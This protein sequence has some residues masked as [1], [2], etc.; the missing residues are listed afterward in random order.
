MEN[1]YIGPREREKIA[2]LWDGYASVREIAAAL[3]VAPKTIYAELKRGNNGQLDK[4]QRTAY[5]PRLAQERFQAALRR[6]GKPREA[7]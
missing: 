2:E 6:R 4:N 1:R 3:G 5:D 7:S